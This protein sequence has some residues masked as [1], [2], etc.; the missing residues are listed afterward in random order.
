MS[1]RVNPDWRA[2]VRARLAGLGLRPEAE[3][4]MIE[5]MA[6][7]LEEQYEEMSATGDAASARNALLARLRDQSLDRV[8]RGPRRRPAG[9]ARV[10]QWLEHAGGLRRDIAHSARSL[11]RSPGV[12]VPAIVALALGIGLTSAMFSVVYDVLIKGL[13]F[14][15]GD[16]IAMVSQTD[17]AA[18]AD[19][20]DA[21][22][23]AQFDAYHA[24]QRAFELFGAYYIGNSN[25]NGGDRPDRLETVRITPDAMEVTGVRP[26]LGRPLQTSDDVADAPLVALIGYQTWIDRFAADS[27]VLGRTLIVNG[28]HHTIIGVMPRG[29]AYPSV[30]HVWMPLRVD[31]ST[32]TDGGPDVMVVGRLRRG[33][34]MDA[35]NTDFRAIAATIA[36]DQVDS[37]SRHMRPIVQSFVRNTI[38]GQVFTLLYAMLVAVGLVLLVACANVANLLLHRAADRM[39]EIGVLAALGASRVAIVRRALVESALLA[40]VAAGLGIAIAVVFMRVYN[41]AMPANERPFWIDIR[42][43]PPVLAFTAGCAIVA[44]MLAGLL[45]ALQSARIDVAAILKEDVHGVSA[46]RIGRV[47]RTVVVVEVAMASAMLVAAGFIMKS[48]INL[49]HLDPG[50]RSA[51]VMTARV[52]LATS[53]TV[54]RAQFF[55]TLDRELSA[56][57]GVD[58]YS[59]GSG[60]P[61]TTDWGGA[62]F[63]IEG[64]TYSPSTRRPMARTLAVS[65]GF[66]PA[67]DVKMI[68]GRR[69]EATDRTG[70][71]RVAVVSERFARTYFPRSDPVGMHIR[72]T[73]GPSATA[74]E[75]LTIVGVMP[76]LFASMLAENPYPPEILTSFWQERNPGTATVA[77]VGAVDPA[78]TLRTIVASLDRD[79]PLYDVASMDERLESS[80][81]AMR[82]FGGTFVVFG[83]S[84][85]I[86]AAIG[87]YAVMAFSVSRRSRELGIRLALGATRA[88]LLRM[89]CAQASLTIGVGMTIGVLLG[90]ILAR[91]LRSV[92]F[93][94]T[95]NDPIVY[96]SVGTLLAAVALFACLVPANRVTRLN[97][98]NALRSD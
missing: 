26:L 98:V 72:V 28:R 62:R 44:G 91:A 14:R 80:M 78:A 22:S 34:S 54:R 65:E 69:I 20:Q 27:S 84:A 97:P 11:A 9:L 73:N 82:L 60:V 10:A 32:M 31:R 81:W 59:I 90:G 67:F 16:R 96:A 77:V 1:D 70:R 38:R 21:M 64:R 4:Q 94:V 17:P 19:Q 83:I 42:L 56:A 75:R 43:Y 51:G 79:V 50:F 2:E 89:I 6:Q 18:P 52:T 23:L 74:G 49:A 87:L 76:T 88:R 57:R 92:L 12:A 85:I 7:H 5:E 68:R 86:L 36:A 25:V 3:A 33:V 45:P 35:A 39:K 8:A 48:I 58:A 66:F 47:S 41:H 63:E 46:L 29:F 37:T 95:A 15:D 61:G 71:E 40:T 13:P 24:R 30:A 55:A 53:D 93:G